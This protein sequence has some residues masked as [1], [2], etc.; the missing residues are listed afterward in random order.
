MSPVDILLNS[1]DSH[2]NQVY[3]M[4]SRYKEND[5]VGRTLNWLNQ[6]NPFFTLTQTAS[7]APARHSASWKQSKTQPFL[8]RLLQSS[9]NFNML[10]HRNREI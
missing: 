2:T 5:V 7:W 8:S 1:V 3:Y 10:K 9:S 6:N 4:N